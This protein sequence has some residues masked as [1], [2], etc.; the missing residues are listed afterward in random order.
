MNIPPSVVTTLST[1]FQKDVLDHVNVTQKHM[2]E[3][4]YY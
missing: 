1:Q 2:Q 3:E 4:C